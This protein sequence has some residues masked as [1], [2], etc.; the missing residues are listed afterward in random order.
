MNLKHLQNF[1]SFLIKIFFNV[2]TT[3][4]IFISICLFSGSIYI[5]WSLVLHHKSILSN[6]KWRICYNHGWKNST[7]IF[8]T[9]AFLKR[10]INIKKCRNYKHIDCSF[11]QSKHIHVNSTPTE[12]LSYFYT[13]KHI[14]F[15]FNFVSW[16]AFHNH[17]RVFLKRIDKALNCLN[18][19]DCIQLWLLTMLFK[20][21]QL[22]L[23]NNNKKMN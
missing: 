23:S 18:N 21:F 10:D 15:I 6:N 14:L 1:R 17:I 22:R 9:K 13:C 16:I 12:I 19:Q 7:M 11:S 8:W 5:F 2:C 3:C 4:H 20:S